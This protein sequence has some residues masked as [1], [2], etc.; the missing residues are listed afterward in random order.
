M[1]RQG[2]V[3]EVIGQ[4]VVL[5]SKARLD[6]ELPLV[7]EDRFSQFG[8]IVAGQFQTIKGIDHVDQGLKR[9]RLV[10]GRKGD[11]EAHAC[12]VNGRCGNLE[13]SREF[14]LPLGFQWIQ[15]SPHVHNVGRHRIP[16]RVIG[17]HG[18]G[19]IS[20]T[21]AHDPPWIVGGHGLSLHHRN[22]FHAKDLT[23]Y[24]SSA[25]QDTS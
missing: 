2:L 3:L 9:L 10:Q 20:H 12:G 13:I 24:R 14:N 21:D 19:G 17:A 7:F 15:T 6:V 1:G 18:A 5:R 23:G 8:Y 11:E 25:A 16:S 4:P 22:P